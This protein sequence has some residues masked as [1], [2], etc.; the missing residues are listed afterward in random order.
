MEHGQLKAP[1]PELAALHL[2]GLLEA[3]Y[4]EPFMFGVR[5]LTLE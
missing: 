4:A 5:L 3:G 2:Q 1:S